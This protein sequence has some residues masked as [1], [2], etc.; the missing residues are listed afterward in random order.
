MVISSLVAKKIEIFWYQR[1]FFKLEDQPIIAYYILGFFHLPK[2][3][4][5]AFAAISSTTKQQHFFK[6]DKTELLGKIVLAK[7][8][9]STIQEVY[10]VII[11]V[12]TFVARKITIGGNSFRGK[13]S[14]ISKR[15]LFCGQPQPN[16]FYAVLLAKLKDTL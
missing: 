7:H 11:I 16:K 14:F 9:K 6:K 12:V 4:R 8:M 1:M 13:C 3:S 15:Q 10:Q 2:T 5:T